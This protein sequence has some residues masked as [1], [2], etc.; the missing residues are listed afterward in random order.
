[1][2]PLSLDLKYVKIQRV[3]FFKEINARIVLSVVMAR[4]D[5]SVAN[6]CILAPIPTVHCRFVWQGFFIVRV[7]SRQ[8][9]DERC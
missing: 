5:F 2:A 1:M 4:H 8:G 7:Q 9:A 6:A 3:C